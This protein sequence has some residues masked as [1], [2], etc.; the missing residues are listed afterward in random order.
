MKQSEKDAAK[1]LSTTSLTEK[2]TVSNAKCTHWK[3]EIILMEEDEDLGIFGYIPVV[4]GIQAL[5][6]VS[7]ELL[8][9]REAKDYWCDRLAFYSEE[10]RKRRAIAPAATAA[11][12]TKVYEEQAEVRADVRARAAADAVKDAPR[13]EFLGEKT[14]LGGPLAVVTG[15]PEKL[16][17]GVLGAFGLGGDL[18]IEE[19]V[20]GLTR[21]AIAAVL[22]FLAYKVGVRVVSGGAAMAER[23]AIRA[24]DF[25]TKVLESPMP[26]G[27][28]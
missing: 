21:L 1:S 10:L 17:E 2:V 6:G 5:S 20:A 25:A 7:D 22:L 26:P 18:K 3:N 4:A 28:M 16:K 23:S 11:A 15:F 12:E 14:L 8:A 9:A 24:T 13:T 19:R 27:L